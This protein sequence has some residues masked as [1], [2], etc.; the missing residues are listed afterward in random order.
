MTTDEINDLLGNSHELQVLGMKILEDVIIE[1]E[2]A[3]LY[4]SASEW[5]EQ[6][7]L[8]KLL[9]HNKPAYPDG[10]PKSEGKKK[11]VIRILI[12]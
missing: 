4:K 8:L 6:P 3:Q 7:E 1:P 5:N 2:F 10:I 11:L 12:F 9:V